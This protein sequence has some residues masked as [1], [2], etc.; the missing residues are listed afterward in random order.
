VVVYIEA[1]Q[2]HVLYA[3]ALGRVLPGRGRR[4]GKRDFFGVAIRKPIGDVH[5]FGKGK[6]W[7]PW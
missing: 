2:V 5:F 7:V 4:E 1:R 6:L 3:E